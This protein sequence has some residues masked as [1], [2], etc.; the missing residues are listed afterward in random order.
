MGITIEEFKY[1]RI[2]LEEKCGI[3][4]N[5]NHQYLVE[6]RLEPLAEK[7]GL[8]NVS[9]LITKVRYEKMDIPI[10][11]AIADAMTTNETL[12]FRDKHPFEYLKN[13]LI[14][15]FIQAQ[16]EKKRIR[17]WSAAC[18]TGQEPYSI[19]MTYLDNF[20]HCSDWQLEV[21][22]TDYNQSILDKAQ[23]GVY[24]Q[25]E[26]QRGLSQVHLERHFFPHSNGWKISDKVKKYIRFSQVN[27]IDPNLNLGI[28]DIIFCRNVLI[29][30]G[31]KTKSLVFQSLANSLT[32]EGSLILGGAESPMGF[33]E[34][35][36]R[37]EGVASHIVYQ[38]KKQELNFLK[39]ST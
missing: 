37:T 34:L 28:F 9:E 5:E 4:L 11:K 39:N 35:W 2:M 26:A 8:K 29:Y 13:I 25:F 32:A 7:H 33:S 38:K 10:C 20:A 15:N 24:S 22:A 36:Q 27:L 17:I 6:S 23:D 31:G 19:V 3:E 18:S 21:I 30:F 1:I 16:P 12:F 14:P